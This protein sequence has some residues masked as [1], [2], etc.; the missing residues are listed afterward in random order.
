MLIMQTGF[1]LNKVFTSNSKGENKANQL[2]GI[3]AILMQVSHIMM[4]FGFS[5]S[6][7]KAYRAQMKNLRRQTLIKSRTHM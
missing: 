7:K 5:L 2:E 1:L 3:L 6:I 4:D